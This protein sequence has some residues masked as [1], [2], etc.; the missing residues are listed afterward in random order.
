MEAR[1]QMVAF[2][3]MPAREEREFFES[4]IDLLSVR[5]DAPR[6]EPHVTLF[7]GRDVQPDRAVQVLH[8]FAIGEPIKLSIKRVTFS[9][10]FTK[11]L[12]VEF[13]ASAEAAALTSAIRSA[14]GSKSDYQFSPHLSL[15]Y[16][17]LPPREKA[18][19]AQSLEMPFEIAMCDA[20]KVITGNAGTSGPADVASWSTLAERRL[21]R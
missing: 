6:F 12:F 16:K 5:F 9:S 13:R 8:E 15:V 18:E 20:V 21:T 17:N 14:T 1:E 7:G 4:L 11:T 3:L 19:V 10:E 2:W